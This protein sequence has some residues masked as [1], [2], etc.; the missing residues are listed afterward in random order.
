M[1]EVFLKRNI[2]FLLEK[3]F[4]TKKKL[5][6]LNNRYGKITFVPEVDRAFTFRVLIDS[7]DLLVR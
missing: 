3:S 6:K 2:N 7:R 4:K 1:I 5:Q